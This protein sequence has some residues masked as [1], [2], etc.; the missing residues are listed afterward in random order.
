MISSLKI[1]NYALIKELEISP[2]KGLNII[3]GETGAGKSIMLG[4]LGLLLGN[5]ADIKALLNEES[6]CFV[7]AQFDLTSN[8]LKSL[9]SIL[10]IDY[11]QHTI[12]RREIT[13]S[14]RSRAFIND[15]PVTLDLLEEVSSKLV[16]IHSQLDTGKLR[17]NEFQID[18]I[19]SYCEAIHLKSK[20]QEQYSQFKALQ[21]KLKQ[22]K[23]Q[24]VSAGKDAEYK[25]YLVEE[26][27]K[28]ALVE[29]EL[30]QL[31]VEQKTLS[32]AEEIK[33]KLQEV[34]QRL[35]GEEFGVLDALQV[36]NQTLQ[37][38]AS[39][40]Q[41]G[42]EELVKRIDS[43]R[44]E[45]E[46]LSAVIEDKFERTDLDPERLNEVNDRIAL[47]N[48]LLKKHGVLDVAELIQISQELN[49]ELST[50]TNIDDQIDQLVKQ[51]NLAEKE[52]L[53]LGERLSQKRKKSIA[54]LKKAIE[55]IVHQLGMEDAAF[56][57]E[58]V[59]KEPAEDGLDEIKMLFSA[60]RG[61]AP[62][63]MVKVASGG[64][65]SRLMFALKYILS[66]KTAMPTVIFDEIDTG[67]S[68]EI[69]IKMGKLMGEMAKNH[70]MITITH[71]PQ[72]AAKGKDHYFVFK[73]NSTDKAVSKIKKMDQDERV[74]HIAEMIGGSSPSESS[75]E[76][77]K[78]L[79]NAQL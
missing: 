57:V 64:E 46:D 54:S 60:N 33:L 45:L 53:N 1:Q 42:F 27:N 48:S 26:L 13:T 2:G 4:A 34:N 51:A 30:E 50:F 8:N 31:E 35:T 39:F 20:Y 41:E 24:K 14:G 40:D 67:I 16:D 36:A 11:D 17:S 43:T 69:A 3:T 72:I 78:E 55:H 6:K 68:G 47:L 7:E 66:E 28:A 71:L 70:Q 12:I 56:E 44:L 10:D 77:A 25:Q 74:G 37:K 65:F 32:N 49:N 5:R 23:E 18:L 15:Q 76:S 79:L 21:K 38:L 59:S 19:D 29:G 75:I 62:Q 22:L 61:V 9:F 73:D 58:I 52:L 63:D